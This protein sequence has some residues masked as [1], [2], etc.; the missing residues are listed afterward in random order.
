VLAA[1]HGHQQ[2]VAFAALDLP[3]ASGGIEDS[4]A[5]ISTVNGVVNRNRV[6][7]PDNIIARQSIDRDQQEASRVKIAARLR[8]DR[9][10]R[11]VL[12]DAD[13]VIARGAL[14]RQGGKQQARLEQ[15]KGPAIRL[16]PASLGANL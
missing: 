9:N 6:H 14:D 15:F 3:Y 12:A 4:V 13:R 7:Q 2:V 10:T 5:A 1:A 11:E 8:G 16:V